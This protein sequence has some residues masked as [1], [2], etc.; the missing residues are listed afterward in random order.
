MYRIVAIFVLLAAPLPAQVRFDAGTSTLL[1]ATGG[2][3]TLY[4]NDRQY[5]VGMAYNPQHGVALGAYEIFPFHNYMVTAGSQGV[6]LST[7]AGGVSLPCVCVAAYQ[8]PKAGYIQRIQIAGFTGMVGGA[9]SSPWSTTAKPSRLGGG[10]MAEFR[11][12]HFDLSTIDAV[13]ADGHRTFIQGASYKRE[14]LHLVMSGGLV[15]SQRFLNAGGTFYTGSFNV[16]GQHYTSFY[17]TNVIVDSVSASKQISVV[18]LTGAV[19]KSSSTLLTATGANAAVNVNLNRLQ[20][21]AGYYESQSRLGQL[22]MSYYNFNEH[23]TRRISVNESISDSAGHRGV[24]FGGGYAGNRFQV[25]VSHSL[26][27]VMTGYTQVLSVSLS[28]R[29]HDTQLQAQT[30]TLPTGQTKWTT[31]QTTYVQKQLTTSHEG[32]KYI[33]EGACVDETDQPVEGCAIQLTL[34]KVKDIVYTN[35]HGQFQYHTKIKEVTIMVLPE[36]FTGGDYT[37]IAA[38]IKIQHDVPAKIVVRRK[39]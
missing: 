36:E 17:P 13:T 3:M 2:S 22:R 25:N 23:L 28:M 15:N 26:Q 39:P 4:Q 8:K 21:S 9:T 31:G 10:V 38:P 30:V 29:I 18:S 11:T 7:E 33:M 32:G 37:V 35:G 24:A 6:G 5:S 19:N 34:G 27:F 1:N 20:A 12:L 16:S 14:H